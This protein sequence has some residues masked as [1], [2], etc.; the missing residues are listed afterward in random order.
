MSTTTEMASPPRDWRRPLRYLW[1]TPLLLAHVLVSLPITVLMIN[2]LCKRLSRRGERL[3]HWA[4]RTWSRG[5]MRIFGFRLKHYGTPLPGAALFVANHVSWIDITLMHSQRFM[6]FVAKAEIAR[7]PLIGWL[8]A[9]G[10]TIYHH[11]GNNESLH[12]VMHQMVQRLQSGQAVGVFPE[13]RTMG[14]AAIGV[15]HARIFQPAVL[16]GVPA[17]PVALKYGLRGSAQTSVAFAPRENFLANFLRLLGDPPRVAEVHFLEPIAAAEDG[18]RR[19]AETCR[20]RI[21][22]AMGR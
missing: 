18:R 12:G 5:M 16:A 8:A 6:G 14:G 2:P 3:D 17:Q 7:W 13:G 21:I 15:F 22:E 19:M 4:V 1:R 9:L 11:R 10:G 20:E